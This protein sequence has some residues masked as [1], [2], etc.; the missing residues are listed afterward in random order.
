MLIETWSIISVLKENGEIAFNLTENTT[1]KTGT[2]L[3]RKQF[4]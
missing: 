4:I 2:N 3:D 1:Y